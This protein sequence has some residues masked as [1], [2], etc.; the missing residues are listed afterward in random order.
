MNDHA[1]DISHLLSLEAAAGELP[2]QP[3]S[4]VRAAPAAAAPA[5]DTLEDVLARD[6]KQA[7]PAHDAMVAEYLESGLVLF[8]DADW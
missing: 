5:L 7:A 8:G 3:T 1:Y 6:L 2:S 4:V